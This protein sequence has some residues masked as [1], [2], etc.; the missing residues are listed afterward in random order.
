[1]INFGIDTT[2]KMRIDGKITITPSLPLC[3]EDKEYLLKSKIDIF[4]NHFK[5]KVISYKLLE[6]HEKNDIM[7][8]KPFYASSFIFMKRCLEIFD[9]AKYEEPTF[10]SIAKFDS[11]ELTKI[12]LSFAKSEM[13]MS[14]DE[15][16]S[17]STEGKIAL[18]SVIAKARLEHI[19]EV[20]ALRQIVFLMKETVKTQV[21]K[22]IPKKTSVKTQEKNSEEYLQT[23]RDIKNSSWDEEIQLDDKDVT[24][25]M[26][27]PISELITIGD[28]LFK[29]YIFCVNHLELSGRELT[30]EFGADTLK[31]LKKYEQQI[32]GKK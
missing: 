1:M 29:K 25:E 7:D 13:K 6:G 32:R 8:N 28:K 5:R 15:I 26:S 9:K 11:P 31:Q 23:L 4:V 30:D 19:W 10:S 12:E 21:D 27:T 20:Y 22:G 18:R 17:L 3:A 14:A 2:V 16:N 24:T